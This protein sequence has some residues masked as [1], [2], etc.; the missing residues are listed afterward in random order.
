[1]ERALVGCVS[2]SR[3]AGPARG[4]DGG[5]VMTREEL[6]TWTTAAIVLVAWL[7]LTGGTA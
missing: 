5:G 2:A 7:V 4:D 1:M 3:V 6:H